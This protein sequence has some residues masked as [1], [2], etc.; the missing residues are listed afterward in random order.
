[1]DKT[2]VKKIFDI[3]FWVLISGALIF[4]ASKYY[5]RTIGQRNLQPL[6]FENENTDED[7]ENNNA[8]NNNV[9]SNNNE[10]QNSNDVE[11]TD[12]EANNDNESSQS[13]N[14]NVYYAYPFELEN[15]DGDIISL[16]K[17]EGTL[18]FVNF[19]A[20]WCPYCV[21]EMP[22]LDAANEYFEENGI[23]ALVIAINIRED[24]QMVRDYVKD[25]AYK[26][27]ILLD[28]DGNVSYEYLTKFGIT[29][30]PTTAIINPDGTIYNF[31]VGQTSAKNIQS[32][33][34][35][36]INEQ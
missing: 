36:I 1:M 28:E 35:K 19:W 32:L 2:K 29:G 24:A 18:L 9:S 30:I 3:V 23:N 31:I 15:M 8:S 27:E 33:A 16:E 7:V 21:K 34:E 13:E 4:V 17:Y 5:Q 25:K 14:E 12:N 11:S 20:T 10:S 22:E 6:V 26:M